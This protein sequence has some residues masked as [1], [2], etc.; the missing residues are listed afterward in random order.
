MLTFSKD[1]EYLVQMHRE[2][3]VERNLVLA[4]RV[5]SGTSESIYVVDQDDIVGVAHIPGETDTV[6]DHKYSEINS[7]LRFAVPG[8]AE[9]I[10]TY[11]RPSID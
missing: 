10:G 7:K 2:G 6:S 11:C 9:F 4:Y 5:K 1:H 3:M 8:N